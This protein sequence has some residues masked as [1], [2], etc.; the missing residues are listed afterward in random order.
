MWILAVRFVS[1]QLSRRVDSRA[2]I[3]ALETIRNLL[4]LPGI[5]P[6]SSI[7]P[8]AVSVP[9]GLQPLRLGV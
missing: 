1:R 2:G 4:H 8:L 7:I 5:E 9:L 6:R 3:D